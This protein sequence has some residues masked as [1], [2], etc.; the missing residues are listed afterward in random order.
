M[1]KRQRRFETIRKFIDANYSEVTS[2]PLDKL[3]YKK[4]K[5]AY[6]RNV[7]RYEYGIPKD[8]EICD[9]LISLIIKRDRI[10]SIENLRIKI[11]TIPFIQSINPNIDIYASTI[12]QIVRD[13]ILASKVASLSDSEKTERIVDFIEAEILMLELQSR[14]DVKGFLL[15]IDDLHKH[16]QPDLVFAFLANPL[17]SAQAR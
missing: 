6:F 15:F 12:N 17:M 13:A 3:G 9:V 8:E 14:Y 11:A 5:D 10:D 1:S 16:T 2:T 7:M 4:T